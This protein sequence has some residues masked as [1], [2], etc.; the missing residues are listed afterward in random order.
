MEGGV[1][2]GWHYPMLLRMATIYM[3]GCRLYVAMYLV[4]LCNN[5][6]FG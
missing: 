4:H 3:Y 2:G 6:M 5:V 1:K